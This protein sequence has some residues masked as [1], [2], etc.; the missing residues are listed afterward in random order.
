[1]EICLEIAHTANNIRFGLRR[2][3]SRDIVC[4]CYSLSVQ[5]ETLHGLTGGYDC[6]RPGVRGQQSL[7]RVKCYNSE[8]NT[9]IRVIQG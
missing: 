7:K 4:Y 5:R 6:G 9:M 2:Y 1:M 8:Q 3:E